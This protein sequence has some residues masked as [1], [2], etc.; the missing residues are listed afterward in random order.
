MTIRHKRRWQRAVV[1]TLAMSFVAAACGG[2][3][4]GGGGAQT[5]D[6]TPPTLQNV[7]TTTVAE[8][9]V[10]G[11]S[12]TIQLF[13]EIGTL[14]PVRGTGSGGSDGQRL[15]A[16]YGGLMA[17]DANKPE[18]NYLQ[19]ESFKPVGG[20]FTKWQLVLRP[21]MKFTD[22]SPFD[23]NA[24]KVNWERAQVPANRCSC[25]G[26]AATIASMTV[27]NPT[28]L[29]VTLKTPNAHFDKGVERVTLNYIASAK[30]IADGTDMTQ[31]PVGAG[32]FKLDEWIRDNRMVM[33]KNPDWL[34]GTK[35]VY[36]DKLTFQVQ[37]NEQQRIDTFK[38]GGSD[39]FYTSIQGSIDAATKDV[40]DSYLTKI[41]VTTGQ[42]F[43]LNNTKAPFDDV[44]IRR[45]I[46]MAFP[47]DI[48]AKEIL[49]NSV[50]A[51]SMSVPGTPWYS[52]A[53][54]LPKYD[55]VEAQKLIDAYVAEKGGQPVT[56]TMLVFQQ[57]LDQDRAKFILTE[58]NKL[59]NFK[60]EIQVNDSPTNIG[61]VLAGDYQWSSWGFPTLD[62]EPGLF[63]TARSGLP[64]NY[65]KY[66]NAEV[67][68]LLDEARAT[69]DNAKRYDNYKKVYEQMA[70]DL[71]FLPYVVT[72]NGFV[73]Q[74]K[75]RG[76]TVYEDG[77]LRFD[78]LWKKA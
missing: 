3:D 52:Q 15:H 49:N 75:L 14:D 24:V 44:R 11:G 48:L 50:P 30:A 39:A 2:D 26:V 35:P 1:A 57:T 7:T 47:R 6:T 23:A 28:T 18:M 66:S 42:T 32:P 43:V 59:K 69:A 78:L 77:I 68:K 67:D 73:C 13:S 40:K 19:A 58:F 16:L 56:F 65:S 27:T 8:T 70:K 54:A 9:P 36:L 29:D 62:P 31:K 51:E 53:Q 64:T 20:D 63:N 25:A 4:G 34:G 71:P 72:R 76:C 37:G 17:F 22:G 21:N 5:N 10:A 41:D 46:A 45:A 12:A 74:P 38:T 55:P 33:S 61:K 60:A